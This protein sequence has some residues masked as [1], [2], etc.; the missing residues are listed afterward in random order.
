MKL[1]IVSD[2]H[3]AGCTMQPLEVVADALVLAGD[4]S[5]GI[6]SNTIAVTAKYRERNLPVLYVLGNHEYEGNHFVVELKRLHRECP[7]L[8]IT[9]LHNKVVFLGGIRFAGT[10]LW[11]DFEFGA[12]KDVSMRLARSTVC[13]FSR[14][15]I[16]PDSTLT[17]ED[18]VRFHRR[19]VR[20]L[21]RVFATPFQGKTVVITHHGFSP[22]SITARYSGDSLNAVYVS[23]LEERIRVWKPALMIHGH[24][25]RERDYHIGETR[26]I[27]NPR[28]RVTPVKDY[29]GSTLELVDNDAFNPSLVIDV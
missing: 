3:L 18:T 22:Q 19:A 6:F 8:G 5:D 15:G 16:G 25:H 17:P 10:T 2:L 28:G 21:E 27:V 29:D 1:H 20:F 13:D 14:I 4:I 26:V 23:D 9:L 7:A 12:K 11:T 24:I